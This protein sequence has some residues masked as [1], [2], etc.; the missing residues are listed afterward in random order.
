MGTPR[1]RYCADIGMFA[2]DRS[3]PQSCVHATEFC[4]KSCYNEKLYKLYPSME[5]ADVKNEA[6]WLTLEPEA[7]ARALDR[8]TRPTER[9]R[10]MTRGEAIR[11]HDDIERV[12]EIC[13][14]VAPRLVW[15]PTRAWREPL[16]R[17][18]IEAE[19]MGIA[20]LVVL[21]S[22]DPTTEDDWRDLASAGWSSMYFGDDDLAAIERRI[23]LR[24]FKCPK[25]WHGLKGH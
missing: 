11:D 16:L 12:K 18:R 7:F 24:M 22:I 10:L 15:L 21:A 5:G 19:L 25:T 4:R 6:S 2:I 3:I 1:H 8:K 9:I 17:A 14:A 20:N 13:E 23:G